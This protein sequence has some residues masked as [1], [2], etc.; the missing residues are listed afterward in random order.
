MEKFVHDQNLAHYR[1]VLSQT[2]DDAKRKVLLELIQAELEKDQ[3]P[4]K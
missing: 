4:K 3:I 1:R 2:T